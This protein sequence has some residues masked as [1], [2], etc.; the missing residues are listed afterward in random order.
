[1][2][3]PTPKFFDSFFQKIINFYQSKRKPVPK[4]TF[5][6]Q[7][8]PGEKIIPIVIEEHEDGF[9]AYPLG[10]KGVIVG[11]GDTKDEAYKDVISAIKFH[12]ETFGIDSLEDESPILNAYIE[13]VRPPELAVS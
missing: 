4:T 12:V 1:M 2:A 7:T 8:K 3:R 11:E 10:I 6:R 9:V 5:S 13:G